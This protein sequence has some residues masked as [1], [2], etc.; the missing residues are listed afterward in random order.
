MADRPFSLKWAMTTLKNHID[1]RT[2]A[3]GVHPC[4]IGFCDN[5]DSH[6]TPEF[7]AALGSF[8]MSRSLLIA[9]ETEMLQAIDGGIG[10]TFKMIVGQIQDEW[11]DMDGNLDAWEGSPDASYKIDAKMRRILIT[12]WT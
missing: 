5:L 8:G 6:T 11:L 4:T 1:E 3:E 9:G 7:L 10:S 2:A 12:Q